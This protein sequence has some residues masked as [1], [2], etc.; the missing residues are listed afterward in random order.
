VAPYFDLSFQHSS[1]AVLRRMRRFG[2]TERFLELVERIRAAAPEAGIRSN[3]IVGFPGETEEDV[4]ELETFLT[5]ARL[6][7]VGV[8]GYS[9]EDGTEAMSFDGHHDEHVVRERVE[10]ITGLA[11]ELVAQRAEDRHGEDVEVLVESVAADGTVEGRAAHQAPEVDGS[12]TVRGLAEPRRVVGRIV[13]ARVVGSE[14]A[15]LLARATE[16]GP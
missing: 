13:G 10:R 11:D 2:D 6:D 14:G 15:D 7:A 9:D 5:G 8:F 4:A 3:V 1:A 12:T 16:G